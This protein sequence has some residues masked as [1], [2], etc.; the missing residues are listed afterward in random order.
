MDLLRTPDARF[1]ELAD[2]P[3]TPHRA[4]VTAPDGA[5]AEMAWVQDGPADGPV[6]LLL[7]GEPTW[8]YL[9]RSM[10]TPLAKGGCCVI[11]PDLIGFGRSDKPTQISDHTYARHVGWLRSLLVDV[12]E[13]SDVTLF[14][15]DW[16]GL[17]GLRLVAQEP[18]LFARVVASNTGL[19]TGDHKM[20]DV[21]WAFRRAVVTAEV[22]DIGRLVA[23]G[24]VRGLSDAARAAYDAPFP[25]EAHKAAGHAADPAD[26]PRRPGRRGQPGGVGGPGATPHAVPGGLRRLRP[27]HGRDGSGAGRHGARSGRARTPRDR[28]RGPLRAGGRGP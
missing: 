1:A 19:P 26:D 16:G 23:S 20:P 3:F 9:Y 5:A 8:S 25:D 4:L 27:D 28:T 6:V 10:I 13:L 2:F 12:L 15:Q 24:C 17:L 14:G 22:L 7:H 11:A 18:A 21:W